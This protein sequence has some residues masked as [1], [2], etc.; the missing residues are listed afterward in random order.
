[1]RHFREHHLVLGLL[2]GAA[3]LRLAPHP[4]GVAPI[5][6]MALFAGAYLNKPLYWLVP[7][8]A[9]AGGDLLTGHQLVAIAASL[10]GFLLATLLGRLVLSRFDSNQR[11]AACLPLA[12]VICWSAATLGAAPA[13]QGAALQ[14]SLPLLPWHLLGDSV[15]A[16]LLFCTYKLTREAPFV[17]YSPQN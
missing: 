4:E 13:E 9:L 7:L 11:I 2:V 6:A 15:Y 16:L 10:A 1:M 17:Y 8:A 5:G 14:S 3:L 12:A